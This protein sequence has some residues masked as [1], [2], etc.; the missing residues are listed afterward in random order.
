MES[1]E[2]KSHAFLKVLSG[3]CTL[4]VLFIFLFIGSTAASGASKFSLPFIG[5]LHFW[6]Y[7]TTEGKNMIRDTELVLIVG[8]L[9]LYTF[10]LMLLIK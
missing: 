1:V 5:D 2:Q 10:K 3:A 7:P 6:A 4:S 9:V 8:V